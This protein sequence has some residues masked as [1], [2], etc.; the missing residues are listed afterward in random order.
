MTEI[1]SIPPSDPRLVPGWLVRLA[2]VGWRLLAAFALALVLILIARTLFTVTA[3][4]LVA[5]IV[6]AT[7]APFVLA[8][9]DRGWSRIKA[10]AVVFLGAMA[11]IIATIVV[12]A[13][14]FVPYIAE[15]LNSL[16]AGVTAL[17]TQLASVSIPP[18]I[19]DAIQFATR[20]IRAWFEANVS[21]LVGTAATIGT[22]AILGTFLTFFFMMDGDKAWIWF[23]SSANTW[24]REAITTS[25]HVALERVGGYLRGTAAIAAFDAVVEGLFLVLL[26]VPNPA[27][28]AI[29]VF[30][31]RFIPYVG[32]LVTT[33][34][35]LL[36]ALASGG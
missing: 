32:P 26:G 17:K 27:P 3:S 14:A 2:A 10:A 7:F 8:L 22:I 23:L 28:L 19:A 31:G 29:I 24:R 33:V 35:L 25:G 16:T 6:A 20:G 5:A 15:T 36:A 34:V 13:I 18:E 21:D 12:I 1:A 4:I 9:R 30:F 11:V